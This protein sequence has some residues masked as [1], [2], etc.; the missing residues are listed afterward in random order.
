LPNGKAFPEGAALKTWLG[1]VGALNANQEIVVPWLNA[2]DNALIGMGNIGTAW[3]QTD[4]SIMP[5]STQY[6]SWD[7]PLMPPVDDA[8]VPQYCG[9]VMYSDMHV[10]G[11]ATDYQNMNRTVPTGCDSASA[12]SP[13]EKAIEFILFDLSSCITP[14]GWT[15]SPPAPDGGSGIQ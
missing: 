9:R 15:P 6:L 5:P 2:R 8:G 10:S 13:D 4:P 1:N 12:L 11:S 7:M 14:V 3:V